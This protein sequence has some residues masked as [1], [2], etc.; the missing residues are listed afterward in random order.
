MDSDLER[1]GNESDMGVERLGPSVTPGENNTGWRSTVSASAK[2]LLRGVR[3]SVDAFGPLKS[4]YRGRS[5]FH[6]GKLRGEAL[7]PVRCPQ[8]SS[9]PQCTKANQRAIESLA[10]QMDALAGRLCRP[11]AVGDTEEQERRRRLEQ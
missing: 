6:F 10:P 4:T 11:V 5:L 2:L 8:P 7:L 1:G 9:V 3:D